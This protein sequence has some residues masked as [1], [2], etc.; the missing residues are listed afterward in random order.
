M[1]PPVSESR[2]SVPSVATTHFAWLRTRMALERTLMAALRTSMSLIGFGFTI[3]QVLSRITGGQSTG[4]HRP[5]VAPRYLGLALIAAGIAQLVVYLVQYREILQH[6]WNEEYQGLTGARTSAPGITPLA[7]VGIL[8][9]FIGLV[10]F[11]V[12][13]FNVT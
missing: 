5:V 6:L 12:V 10:A 4:A 1:D 2:A 8:M 9:V 11:A 3:V 7:W 13:L